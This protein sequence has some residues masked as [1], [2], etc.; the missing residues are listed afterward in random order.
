MTK[1]MLDYGSNQSQVKENYM[2]KVPY[3]LYTKEIINVIKG[4]VHLYQ[5]EDFDSLKNIEK[6]ILIEHALKACDH[7]IEIIL[8][9]DT[10][11]LL[12]TYLQNY[13]SCHIWVLTDSIKQDTYDH[14]SYAFNYMFSEVIE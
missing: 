4:F 14:F 10:N 2:I 1:T 3:Y 5:A 12:S 7:D 13:A 8:S 6:D 9:R 11:K